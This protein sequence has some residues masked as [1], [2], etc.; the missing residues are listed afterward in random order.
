MKQF[1]FALLAGA[2]GVVVGALVVTSIF[3]S[4]PVATG[5]NTNFGGD[6][7]VGTL[8]ADAVSSASVV[9]TTLTVGANGST[10]SEMKAT[11]CALAHGGAT[12]AATSTLHVKCSVTG[13]APGDVVF[14]QIGA[15]STVAQ[16]GWMITQAKAGDIAGEISVALV[17]LTGVAATVPLG[18]ASTTNIWYID[19]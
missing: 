4:A 9:P 12:V 19:N 7:T 6:L 17:N 11:T 13:V 2:L 16:A 5:G 8:Y 14:A 15:T 18:I 3:D 1:L 10:I